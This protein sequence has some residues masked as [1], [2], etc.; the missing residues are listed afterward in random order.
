MNIFRRIV[1]FSYVS[2]IQFATSRYVIICNHRLFP[3]TRPEF[4]WP[5]IY[6]CNAWSMYLPKHFSWNFCL[7]YSMKGLKNQNNSRFF[8]HEF[9]LKWQKL[10]WV[11]KI[12]MC[13]K[14]YL[15]RNATLI[16][17]N[18]PENVFNYLR[19]MRWFCWLSNM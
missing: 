1:C 8:F 10:V 12:L 19:V 2:Q 17:I 9:L 3:V 4:L 11:N 7:T 16:W 6:K 15:E 18:V 13:H 5:V 14:K